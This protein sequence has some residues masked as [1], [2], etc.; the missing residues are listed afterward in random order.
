MNTSDY[1]TKDVKPLLI[2]DNVSKAK[3]LFNLLTFTHLPVLENGKFIGLIAENDVQAIVEDKKP[4]SEYNY[5]FQSFFARKNTNWFE[6][7]KIFALNEATIIPVV[8]EKLGYL[9]YYEL[10]DILHIFNSTPFLNQSGAVMVVSKGV[11]DY[12]FSEISQIIESNNAKMLGAFISNINEETVEVTVKISDHDLNNTIQS[13][14]RYNYTILNSFHV[15]EYLNTLKE[16]SDYLQK[17]L[18]I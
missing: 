13:F 11:D 9:G 10:A 2:T 1:I 6:L 8:T 15:D 17:Y 4:I 12:S 18:D 14:R 3:G 5:L 16:R 7:L